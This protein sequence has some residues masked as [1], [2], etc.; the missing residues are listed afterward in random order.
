M[1]YVLCFN[2]LLL[3][4][5]HTYQCLLEQL[6]LN[7]SFFESS[8]CILNT[9]LGKLWGQLLQQLPLPLQLQFLLLQGAWQ[10]VVRGRH[11]RHLKVNQSHL[12]LPVIGQHQ[13]ASS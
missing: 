11:T 2:C 13:T 6:K 8:F 7:L 3:G 9:L 5:L 10:G 4:R 1:E 12:F